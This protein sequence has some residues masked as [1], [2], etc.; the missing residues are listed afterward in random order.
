M[1]KTF[2]LMVAVFAFAM[3]FTSCTKEGQYMP[4]QKISEIV[5]TKY[6]K[7]PMGTTISY[8]ER[9]VWSWNGK[10]L[11][12]ID[13]YDA[14][15]DRSSTSLFRYDG[16]NRIE[17][18]DYKN[19]TAKYEYDGNSIK[20]ISIFNQNGSLRGKYEF[21]HKGNTLTAINVTT[22]SGKS[23]EALPFNP[24]CFFLPENA[25][26]QVMESAATKGS[27]RIVLTWSGKNVTVADISGSEMATYK[28]TYD[29]YSNPF[30][31]LLDMGT[32]DASMIFSE[33]NVVREE[34]TTNNTTTA[35]DFRYTYDKKYPVKKE[36]T[37]VEYSPLEMVE[38]NINCIDEY[39][40]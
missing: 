9:E 21:E 34:V 32:D 36:W 2:A 15:G 27:S 10:L 26:N 38:Y 12:Y 25:A 1:K 30:K 16:D 23:M 17:E 22:N 35:T 29:E 5:H 40:Y 39:K 18:I 14:N 13:Y 33:N 24:L 3:V 31:A 28:W 19:V 11:S 7:M 6:Y 8:T 4:K 37:V 20:T